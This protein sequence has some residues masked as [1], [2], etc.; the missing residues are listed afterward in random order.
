MHLMAIA[1]A[2]ASSSRSTLFDR[3]SRETPFITN[4]RRAGS[5]TMEQLFDAAESRQ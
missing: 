2:A 3:M 1:G 5:S 4:L